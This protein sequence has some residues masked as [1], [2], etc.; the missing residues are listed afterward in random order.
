[1]TPYFTLAE[2]TRSQIASR[3][4]ID[5]I[6]DA[7]EVES[8]RQLT[9]EVLEPLRVHFARPVVVTSGYRSP[10]LNAMV[11][12]GPASQH[13]R[14]QAV[15]FKS[16]G[17]PNLQ[18]ALWIAENFDFDQ[19]LL[20]FWDPRYPAA[21]W[22]HCSYTGAETNRNDVRTVGRSGTAPGLP[23]FEKEVA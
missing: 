16:P 5:N 10:A 12:S 17:V 4:G 15:D 1:M 3:R 13:V 19:L 23:R 2:M 6:P 18:V 22:I 20:E 7:R 21:G 8:L 11:G 9:R 14:G